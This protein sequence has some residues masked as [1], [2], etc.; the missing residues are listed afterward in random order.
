[1]T[2]GFS[3]WSRF[4]Y[5]AGS[6]LL[7]LGQAGVAAEPVQTLAQHPQWFKLL[8]A[9]PDG[10]S[11]VLSPEFFLAADGAKNPEAEL[12][13]TLAA[14]NLPSDAQAYAQARC[15][16]PARVLWLTQQGLLP[17]G[18]L[19]HITCPKL[20]D[21]ARMEQ[22]TSV[23][24]LLVSGY[25]GNPA[26]TFG[27]SMLRLNTLGGKSSEGLTDMGVNFGALV[28][29]GESTPVY[30]L[31][32]LLGGYQAGFSDKLYHSHDLMY[33]RTEYRDMWDYEL[34]LN[35]D[36]RLMLVYHLWELVGKKFTYY[37]LREN[38]AYR[39]AALL[40]VARNDD[41]L[42]R[43]ALWFAPVEMFHRLQAAGQRSGR[44][45]VNSVRFIPSMERELRHEFDALDAG[46]L[47]VAQALIAGQLNHQ[48]SAFQSLGTQ[49]QIKVLNTLLSY[50]DYRV[51]AEE[52]HVSE[53]T[54]SGQNAA[55]QARL[56]LPVG[57]VYRLDIPAKISPAEAAPPLLTA[58]GLGREQGR[59]S[60]VR[61]QGA[62]FSYELS[63]HNGLTDGELVMGDAVLHIYKDGQAEINKFDL[64]R[65]AK[66][67]ASPS[68]IVGES[69]WSWQL[70]LG[71]RREPTPASRALR[72]GGNFG[73]GY[74]RQLGALTCYVMV[75]IIA[76]SGPASLG[77]EPHLGVIWQSENWKIWARQGLRYESVTQQFRPQR[78]AEATYKI[79]TDSALRLERVDTGLRQVNLSW[80]RYW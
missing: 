39:M 2:Y 52:P 16:F 18:P 34:N 19:P 72:W 69:R 74:A 3:I 77:A 71:A 31:K 26:S 78:H 38:C 29:E 6:I 30:V 57:S 51:T 36:E 17:V 20:K 33:S 21:W 56:R 66:I 75:D 28:P 5:M 62:P 12:R 43:S 35:D 25:L 11:E 48:E 58:I 7:V 27:H 45:W 61:L 47:A 55:L 73:A 14:L 15:R 59:G 68:R 13:A 9:L 1:M 50:Y 64:V 80:V 8:H 79:S 4:F 32:G 63:G 54:R 40:A 65:V 70:R 42:N 37:F 10:R 46:E 22:L 60:F 24:L 44:P 49:A 67:N 76:L 23:S 53:A 41:L